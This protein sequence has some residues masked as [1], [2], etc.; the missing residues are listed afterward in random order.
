M[1]DYDSRKVNV[2]PEPTWTPPRAHCADCGAKVRPDPFAECEARCSSCRVLAD[3]ALA[4]EPRTTLS[5]FELA[6]PLSGRGGPSASGRCSAWL[7]R[8]TRDVLARMPAQL[9]SGAERAIVACLRMS[10]RDDEAH[11]W[12]VPRKRGDA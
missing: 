12:D 3:V 2:Q 6:G 10:H 1:L 8:R 7:D 11:V 9:S 4:S 5:A